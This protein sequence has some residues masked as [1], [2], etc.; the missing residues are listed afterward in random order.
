MKFNIDATTTIR[1]KIGRKRTAIEQPRRIPYRCI[2]F[3][4]PHHRH[5]CHE[6]VIQRRTPTSQPSLVEEFTRK[7]RCARFKHFMKT[8]GSKL[9]LITS[10]MR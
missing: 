5:H 4:T 6:H 9:T 3:S 7:V 1:G 2:F 8:G 10:T